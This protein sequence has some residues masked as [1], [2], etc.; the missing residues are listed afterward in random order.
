MW[1]FLH[2]EIVLSGLA[3]ISLFAAAVLW[4]VLVKDTRVR[5]EP[6]VYGAALCVATFLTIFGVGMLWLSADELWYLLKYSFTGRV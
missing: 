2:G 6:F 4:V 3:V 5:K 1:L